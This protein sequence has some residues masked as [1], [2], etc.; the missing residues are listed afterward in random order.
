MLLFFS[1]KNT[2]TAT[3][4]NSVIPAYRAAAFSRGFTPSAQ[5]INERSGGEEKRLILGVRGCVAQPLTSR[6][7]GTSSKGEPKTVHSQLTP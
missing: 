2:K 4:F 1:C 7:I 3:N 6:N 5:W